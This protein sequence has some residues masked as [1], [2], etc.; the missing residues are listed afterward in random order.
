[1]TIRRKK[2]RLKRK[3]SLKRRRT[4]VSCLIERGVPMN[5]A[6]EYYFNNKK[7]L[8]AYLRYKSP[9]QIAAQFIRNELPERIT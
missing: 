1:M 6:K 5:I 9:M 3:V 8:K 2:G 7:N 4:I